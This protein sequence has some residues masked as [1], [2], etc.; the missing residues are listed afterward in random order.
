MSTRSSRTW[1]PFVVAAILLAVLL[2]GCTTAP[3]GPAPV[4]TQATPAPT[5]PPTTVV[6]TVVR[7][8]AA[9]TTPFTTQTTVVTTAVPKTPAAPANISVAIKDFAFSPA[10]L[11]VPAGTTVTWTNQDTLPHTVVSDATTLFQVGAIFT[12]PSLSQ[13]QKFSYTFSTPGTVT[14]HCSVHPFMGGTVTV[15]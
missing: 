7:T 10:A 1:L 4:T 2:A 3:S 15:T 6:T 14:Y 8:T 13:G 5:A 11:T 12:S 9:P